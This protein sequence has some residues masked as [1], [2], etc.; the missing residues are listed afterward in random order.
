MERKR[1]VLVGI[2][3]SFVLAVPVYAQEKPKVKEVSVQDAQSS[4]NAI[5]TI[6]DYKK[7]I[8]LSEDQVQKMKDLLTGLKN[9][10]DEKKAKL[11]MLRNDL[12]Q[13]IKNREKLESIKT[14]LGKMADVQVDISYA[15]IETSRRIEDIMNSEQL[16]NWHD[17]QTK[18][19]EKI[20]GQEK[21]KTDVKPSK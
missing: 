3:L 21:A 4:K 9:S 10:F 14:Q 8:G 20:T 7:E 16:K 15:D 18:T 13:M 5:K 6:F 11:L 1:I 2:L 19:Q 12:V 17:L